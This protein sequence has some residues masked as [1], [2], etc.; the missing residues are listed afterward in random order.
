MVKTRG[1]EAY[2]A[3]EDDV[4]EEAYEGD[5]QEEAFEAP[6]HDDD[7]DEHADVGDI[8]E[9]I[10]GFPGGPRDASLLTHYVQHVAY[11]ISQGRDRGDMLKLILHGKKV[12]K[13]GPCAEGIQHIVLNSSLMPLIEI[14][15]D[16]LDKGLVLGF[17]ER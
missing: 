8:E 17:I 15:Y 11:D 1:E 3:Y 2:Q 5:V 9:D 13:L 7:E 10:G 4:Q 6:D 16:Y 14:C 12:N